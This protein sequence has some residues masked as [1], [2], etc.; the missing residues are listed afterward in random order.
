MTSYGT[1]GVTSGIATQPGTTPLDPSATTPLIAGR[2]PEPHK[3]KKRTENVHTGDNYVGLAFWVHTGAALVIMA[4]LLSEL[5]LGSSALTKQYTISLFDMHYVLPPIWSV[6]AVNLFFAYAASKL[7]GVA[8]TWL[9]VALTKDYTRPLVYS[10]VVLSLLPGVGLGIYMVIKEMYPLAVVFFVLTVVRMVSLYA[11]RDRIP[12]AVEMLHT[13]ALFID[14]YP[15]PT[16]VAFVALVPALFWEYFTALGLLLAALLYESV[17]MYLLLAFFGL[18][19]MWTSGVIQSVLR[20]TSAGVCGVWYHR[21]HYGNNFEIEME[22]ERKALVETYSE[23]VGN[24]LATTN[25]TLAFVKQSLTESFGSVTVA[26]LLASDWRTSRAIFGSLQEK[27]K[28]SKSCFASGVRWI[29]TGLDKI[30]HHFNYYAYTQIGIYHKPYCVAAND[31]WRLLSARGSINILNDN[32]IGGILPLSNI[33]A[34]TFTLVVGLTITYVLEGDYYLLAGMLSYSAGGSVMMQVLQVA[35]S[36]VVTIIL[37]FAEEPQVLRRNHP[38]LYDSFKR[39]YGSVCD[40][41]ADDEERT[42]NI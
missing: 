34:G 13:V 25:P 14:S 28:D 33:V 26:A 9:W 37:C 7:A 40:L 23:N 3:M 19:S 31:T 6:S 8:F 32:I 30:I 36:S 35:E 10:S 24:P 21:S 15:G 2:Q 29:V 17:T 42:E 18:S 4:T 16:R 11:W 27:V 38:R 5:D 20:V 22:G 12:Y 39:I 1:L 41:F